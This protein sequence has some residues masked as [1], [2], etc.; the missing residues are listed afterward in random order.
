MKDLEDI[1][2]NTKPQKASADFAERV[3][4]QVTE[5][6]A[7]EESFLQGVFLGIKPAKVPHSLAEKVMRKIHRPAPAL[8]DRKARIYI[9]AACILF[10]LLTYFAP[11]ERTFQYQFPDFP[12]IQVPTIFAFAI[13]GCSGLLLLDQW[14]RKK[15]H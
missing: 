14:L 10:A 1:L 4:L 13:L 6:A 7:A 12:S 15:L 5:N 8:I 2:R 9:G 11:E 3:M